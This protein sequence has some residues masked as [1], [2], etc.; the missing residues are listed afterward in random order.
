MRRPP[1]SRFGPRRPG[2]VLI[3]ACALLAACG[4]SDV[5]RGLL[6]SPPGEAPGYVY[7]TPLISSTT[8]MIEA[9]SGDVV[10]TWESEYAPTGSV[11]LLDNGNLLR[12]GKIPEVEVFRGGGQGGRLQEFTWDGE[13]VWDFRFATEEHLLHHDTALL[14]NG[15][16]LAI[17]WEAKSREEARQMGYREEMTPERGLWP[18]MI[19]E[20]EPQGSTGGRVVWEWHAWDHMIQ[21]YDDSAGNFADPA[22]HPELVDVN[23]GRRVPGDVT[24]DD[25]ARY[26]E[27]GYVPEGDGHNPSSDLMHTNAIAYNADLDQIVLSP[28]VFSEIWVIDHST[29]TAEA[30]GSTGGRWGRGGDLLYRWGNPQVYGQGTEADQILFGQHDI[31]WVPEGMPGAGNFTVFN[32]DNV[33]PGGTFSSVYEFVAPT[34]ASGRYVIEDGEAF[35]PKETNWT[36]TAPDPPNFYGSFISGA[37]RLAGGNTLITS[38]PQGRFFE[39]TT[40]GEIVWEFWSPTSGDVATPQGG[41]AIGA[42]P[43]AVF[44]ATYIAG[45]HPALRGRNLVPLDPQPRLIPPPGGDG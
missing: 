30:R 28:R 37:H 7:Y 15:N 31:R 5:P 8:Y 10:H 25:I 14:P 18:D 34:D 19:V 42:N 39:V 20:I 23:A 26:R 27:L 40:D 16:I 45:D 32:N 17:A 33:R 38:G 3:T 13:I 9:G 1:P 22:A 41:A 4:T 2:L 6:V 24:Q 11:Y 12:G 44:R 36:Y 43:Y 21:D 29:T 35:G